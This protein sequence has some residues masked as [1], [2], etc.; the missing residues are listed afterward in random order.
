[1]S[2]IRRSHD[3]Y[4]IIQQKNNSHPMAVASGALNLTETYLLTK[5]AF[6]EYIDHLTPGGF[7]TIARHGGIRLLNLGAEVLK[8]RGVKDYW[9]RMILVREGGARQIFFLKNGDFTEQELDYV[10]KFF[11]ERRDFPMYTPRMYEADANVFTRL[12]HEDQRQK[13]LQ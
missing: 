11:G 13:V 12:M 4:D 5:E 7:L 9:K 2:F 8:D 3:L 1:R 10:D 6:N